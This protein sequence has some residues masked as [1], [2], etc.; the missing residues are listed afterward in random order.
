MTKL[1][2]LAFLA[3]LS[4]FMAVPGCAGKFPADIWPA[5]KACGANDVT[6]GAASEVFAD[7]VEI[8]NGNPA[9]ETDLLSMLASDVGGGIPCLVN[10][11]EGQGGNVGAA[12]SKF[13]AGHAKELSAAAARGPTACRSPGDSTPKT[14]PTVQQI[15]E[16]TGHGAGQGGDQPP[17]AHA[18]APDREGVQRVNHPAISLSSCDL[19]CGGPN[20]SIAP[21][22]GCQCWRADPK[23]WR[24]SRWIPLREMPGRGLVAENGS[25]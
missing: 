24:N 14:G 9:G 5:L 19:A 6:W 17:H 7:L 20:T 22:D 15:S 21:P 16:N 1:R 3:L 23:N 4:V 25:L 8:A 18:L 10:Y 11:F 12:A 2:G 13:K